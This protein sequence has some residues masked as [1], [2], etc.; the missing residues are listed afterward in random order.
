MVDYFALL[1]LT[2]KKRSK[3]WRPHF[4]L[5]QVSNRMLAKK[6]SGLLIEGI[7]LGGGMLVVVFEKLCITLNHQAFV[8]LR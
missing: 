1:N 3:R 4:T 7:Q 8:I 2:E 6:G 5:F